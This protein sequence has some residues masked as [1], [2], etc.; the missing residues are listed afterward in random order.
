[1]LSVTMLSLIAHSVVM[2]DVMA[3]QKKIHLFAKDFGAIFILTAIKTKLSKL[4][5]E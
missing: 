2:L 3:P 4:L 5:V 1:M